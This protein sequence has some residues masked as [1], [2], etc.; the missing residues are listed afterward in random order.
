MLVAMRETYG[1]VLLKRK[2][3]RIRKKTGNLTLHTRF[4]QQNMSPLRSLW[5]ALQRPT[6]MLIFSP[7]TL[8][9]SLY[10]AF[11]FGLLY[12]LFTT[13]ASVF[14]EQYNFSTGVSG[15]AYLG[16]GLGMAVGVALF[17]ILSDKVASK[18]QDKTSGEQWKP[19]RRLLLM[20]WLGPVLPLGFFWY[21][22]SAYY[23][24]HWIVPLVGTGFIGIGSLMI[25]VRLFIHPL[26]RSKLTAVDA[27]SSLPGR[28]IRPTCCSVCAR[29]QHRPSL[30]CWK[31]SPTSWS[32]NVC[33]SRTGLG[34]FAVRIHCYWLY[35]PTCSVLS[36][37]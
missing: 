12:L 2:S 8:L 15:L 34:K 16:V 37:W 7:I 10:C 4:E 35:C 14:S 29:C 31:F 20:I 24:T 36:V 26:H 30:H 1:P 22:W 23:K 18:K 32:C 13:F 9:L 21:G 25:M 28:C 3:E 5:L 33:R 17:S 27:D 11:V 6:Y 19:E